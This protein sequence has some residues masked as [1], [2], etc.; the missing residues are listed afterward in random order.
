MWSFLKKPDK[1]DKP[2]GASLTMYFISYKDIVSIGKDAYDPYI[3]IRF[4]GGAKN[5]YLGGYDQKIYNNICKKWRKY[6][7]SNKSN[8]SLET[9]LD[10]LLENIDIIPG[11][12]EYQAAEKRFTENIEK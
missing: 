5:I 12:S 11:G 10:K 4:Y 2:Q 6:H 9:K 7:A 8:T 3:I 1:R